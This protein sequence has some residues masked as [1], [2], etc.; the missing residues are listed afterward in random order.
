MHAIEDDM[1]EVLVTLGLPRVRE[2]A[3]ATLAE[4]SEE[5]DG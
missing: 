3:G 1:L 2:L 4:R 5:A